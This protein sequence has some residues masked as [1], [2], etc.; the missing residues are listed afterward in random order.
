MK[1]SGK[2][3]I[4]KVKEKSGRTSVANP[5]AVTNVNVG[6]GPRTGNH[7]TPAKRGEF[8]DAKE[9]RQPLATAINDAYGRRTP[10]DYVDSK[11]EPIRSNV[12]EGMRKK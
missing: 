12:N 7:G 2:V 8:M 3:L 4:E 6:M 1:Y 5:H 9:A 10:G 11:L